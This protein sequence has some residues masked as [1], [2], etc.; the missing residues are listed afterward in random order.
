VTP[1]LI[2]EKGKYFVPNFFTSL[3]FLVGIWA[4]LFAS[5]VLG[6]AVIPASQ[7]VWLAANLIIFCVLFDKL[8]G[9]AARLMKASSEFGAQFDSLADLVAFG[10]APGVLTIYAYQAYAPDWYARNGI[11]VLV[12]ISLYVLCAALRLA[13][14]N[15]VD[16]ETY[17]DYF[18]GMP[19]TF[20][21]GT[22]ALTVILFHKYDLYNYGDGMLQ[23]VPLLIQ[24]FC[25]IMM[26]SPFLLPKVKPRKNKFI[27]GF[28][29]VSAVLSYV[30]GLAMT[31]PE[32]LAFLLLLYGTVG[33]VV[34]FLQH[35]PFHSDDHQHSNP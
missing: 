34:G 14:Y 8:D 3:N 18:V 27:N 9:F 13:R 24:I 5:G 21:G 33:F 29:L 23:R 22:M 25:A 30:C 32:V 19:T 20:A 35:N 10:I 2:T 1:H 31:L 11:L 4:I 26:I 17:P 6:G 12:A 28:Q 15:A 16:S 7:P